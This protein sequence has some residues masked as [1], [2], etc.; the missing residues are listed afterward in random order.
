MIMR[1]FSVVGAPRGRTILCGGVLLKTRSHNTV[2]FLMLSSMS[3]HLICVST[4]I[5][6]FQT[7][8]MARTLLICTCVMEDIEFALLPSTRHSSEPLEL[9]PTQRVQPLVPRGVLDKPGLVTETVVA[10]LP[11]AV[12][13]GLMLSVVAIGELTVLVK[14]ESTVA[15]RDRLILQHSHTGLESQFLLIKGHA[16]IIIQVHW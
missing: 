2:Q 5:I 13:V 6:T 11:H 7:V 14:P 16:N 8:K 1:L 12:E 10:V 9:V 15:F 3:H 4:V